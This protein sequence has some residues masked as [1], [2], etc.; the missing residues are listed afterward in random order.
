[1]VVLKS[2][3]L[4]GLLASV[5]QCVEMQVQKYLKPT[6]NNGDFTPFKTFLD[7]VRSAKYEDYRS[8]AVRDEVAFKEM[9]DHILGMYGGVVS[10]V[11]SFVLEGKYGDC[12]AI[13]EQPTVYQLGIKEIAQPP[14]NSVNS[15]KTDRPAP[16]NSSHAD[17]PL[18]LGLRDPFHNP[19]SC[20][21]GTIPM[22]R[23]TLERLTRFRTL[24]DFFSKPLF[25]MGNPAPTAETHLHARAEQ[26]VSNFGGNS[27]MSLWNPSGAFSISQQ[28]YAVGY[29]DGN[30][31]LQTVEGGW[32]MD[33][34]DEPAQSK[35]TLFIFWTADGYGTLKCWNL[36]CAAFTQVNDGWYLDGPWDHYSTM[37]G[38]Q[39]GFEMQWKL[40]QGNW[41]LFLKGSGDYEAVGYYSGSIFD[42][43]LLAKGATLIT[44]GGEV[45]TYAS[46]E[47]F[48][49]MGSGAW[50]EKGWG[51]AAFHNTIF[52]IARDETDGVGV[53]T[54]MA[55]V[56][57]SVCYSIDIVDWTSG[58]EWGTYFYFG[59][60]GNKGC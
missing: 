7:Q 48:P 31:V 57:E 26:K 35:S 10:N 56:D 51:E 11:T 38:E 16:G 4:V 21:K 43:G 37:D 9:K 25:S 5:A 36:D 18:K 29:Q 45:A 53:W 2:L 13:K 42:G 27:W 49:E 33:P 32:R 47:R 59:G 14:T 22:S 3:L 58:G 55:P 12:I 8:S 40:Y 46:D 30:K 23:L 28:W 44:C 54:N 1:M 24:N 50:A 41:W 19:I 34:H 20:P 15:R 60:P 52:Y 39:W 6:A 17:S